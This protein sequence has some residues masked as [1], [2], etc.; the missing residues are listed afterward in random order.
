MSSRLSIKIL[1]FLVVLVPVF[2]QAEELPDRANGHPIE[3]VFVTVTKRSESLQE[4][5]AAVSAFTGDTL[6]RHN[7]QDYQA[8]ADLTP[9]MVTR[10]EEKISI[11]GIGRSREGASPVAFHVNG[12][13]LGERGEPFYD[14]QAVE[15]LRGP[16]GTV[17]GR[18]ATAGAINAKWQ[19]PDPEWSYGGDYRYSDIAEKQLRAYLNFP[20][21]GEDDTRLLG[22]I[23]AI[24]RQKDGLIDNLLTPSEGD[25]PY[26]VD[27]QFLRLYLTSEVSDNVLV[28]VRAIRYENNPGGIAVVAS[29][30]I[31]T[32]E[33][34][35]LEELGAQPLP[36]DL[37]VV[38]S[39]LHER[40]PGNFSKFSRVDGDVTWTLD[41]I[42]WLGELDIDLVGG[43][44][45]SRERNIYDLDGT[46]VAI[47]DGGNFESG[48]KRTA[49]LRFTS[50]YTSGFDWLLGLFWYRETTSLDR[51]VFAR[52]QA[53]A[54][55]F[56]PGFPSLPVIDPE[57]IVDAQA[58]LIGERRLDHSEAVFLNMNFDLATLFNVEPDV[59]LNIGI[60]QNED[61]VDVKV[62]REEIS[63]V[64]PMTGARVP[65]VDESNIHVDGEFQA[66]TGEVGA[67][68]FYSDESLLYIKLAKGYKPGL[69]Q[70]IDSETN[71]VNPEYLDSLE[72]GWKTSFLNR[73]LLVNL[74]AF[75][76]DYTDLQVF[77]IISTGVRVDNAGRAFIDGFEAELQW[78]PNE[79]FYSQAA[80]SWL[81][82]RFDEFCGR[83]DELE[84]Q[85][86]Q[87][88][89]TDELPHNFEGAQLA[90]APKFSFSL[91]A[92]YRFNLDRFGS[93]TPVL[94][95]SWVDD[96]QRREFDNP[97]DTIDAFSNT[98]LRLVWESP[99]S[100][101]K[102][103]AFVEN[104]E[105]HDDIFFD[106]FSLLG[107]GDYSLL[108]INPPRTS[109]IV[110]EARL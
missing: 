98:T 82:A 26:N 2:M 75:T 39:R 13:F 15:V 21:F 105:N 104:I 30:S 70:R 103:Q 6:N 37:K 44:M 81:D 48:I 56:I 43:V 45:R 1:T 65:V 59:R 4:I 91:L 12:V 101:F 18:N 77:K 74:T 72:L 9:N 50:Q 52:A 78:S 35:N 34:G 69:V 53:T 109:G 32:R 29:P 61:R 102:V 17:F 36:P 85:E 40:F 64:E 5:S 66:T 88:G 87:P 22:R 10:S 94:K 46:E 97:I 99:R 16:S 25:D 23:A 67:K 73:S 58:F 42:P 11:R 20:V 93:L 28:G 41:N 31:T 106:H 90:D 92:Q 47:V 63:A 100:R 68:W 108:T 89:C 3:E 60:R 83:D 55:T 96:S 57:V 79:A 95:T 54:D 7:I 27:D 14:L 110:L 51:F 49:E 71:A 33:R 24:S 80:F 62:E 19:R 107:P 76:Y 8:L 86:A 38:R 84:N